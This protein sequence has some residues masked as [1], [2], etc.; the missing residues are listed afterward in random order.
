[1][2]KMHAQPTLP[3]HDILAKRYAQVES[4]NPNVHLSGGVFWSTP[5]LLPNSPEINT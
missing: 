1:M 2:A 4:S 5:I 3:S